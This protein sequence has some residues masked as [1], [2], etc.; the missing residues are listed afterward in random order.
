MLQNLKRTYLE[1]KDD[2]RAYWVLD[3]ILLV[4]PGQLEALR[5]R[6]FVSAR[7]GV[8]AA[9]ERDLEA[10]LA[11]APSPADEAEVRRVLGELRGRRPLVN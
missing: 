3:R 9:A 10:Y 2:V 8:P 5:D 6:G 11:R 7:L 4:Q 1:R